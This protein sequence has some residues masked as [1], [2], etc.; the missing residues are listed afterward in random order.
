VPAVLDVPAEP[1]VGV[2]LVI[3]GSPVAEVTV[4]FLVL[5]VALPTVT[6][7]GPV[8][9]PLGTAAMIAVGFQSVV[10][11]VC[12]LVNVTVPGVDPKFAPVMVTD[13]P[14]GPLGGL[15]LVMIGDDPVTVKLAVEVPVP[16]GVVTEIGPLVAAGGTVAVI[17]VEL[18]MVKEAAGVP[19]NLTAVAPVKFVPVIV[20]LVFTGPLV[21]VKLVMLGALPE[22][23]APFSATITIAQ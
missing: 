4:K 5:L 9:A 20:T 10:A 1:E 12:P 19:L 7:T 8:I 13:T 2:T 22:P 18:L 6:T 11:A 3:F 23:D 15:S 17:C 21:G 14:T 16:D